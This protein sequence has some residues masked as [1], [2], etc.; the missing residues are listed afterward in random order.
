MLENATIMRFALYAYIALMIVGFTFAYGFLHW[1]KRQAPERR[2][3]V[4]QRLR[5]F[6]DQGLQSVVR[7]FVWWAVLA[8]VLP[9][10]IIVVAIVFDMTR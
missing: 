1:A 6:S 10:L 8:C 5:R 2:A 4:A 9:L 7:F 3:R